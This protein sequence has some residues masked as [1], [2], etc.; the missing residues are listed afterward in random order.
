[1][2]LGRGAN[3]HGYMIEEIWQELAKAK[4]L[5]WEHESTKRSW[6]LQNLKCVLFID[7]VLCLLFCLGLNILGCW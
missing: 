6:E 4:Y 1:M 5:Q 7:A 3:P 2:D